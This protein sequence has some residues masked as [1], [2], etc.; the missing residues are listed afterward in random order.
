QYSG[1]ILE[2]YFR[3]KMA[4]EER[5]TSIGSYWDA[6]G[7]NKIDLIA[8]NDLDKTAIVAEVKRNPKKIDLNLLQAKADSIKKELA[9]YKVELRGLSMNDM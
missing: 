2:R 5:I 7:L 3:A 9:K 6:K 1:L 4:E 8:L